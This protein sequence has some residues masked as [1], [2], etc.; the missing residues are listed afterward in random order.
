MQMRDCSA[1]ADSYKL[2]VVKN[3]DNFIGSNVITSIPVSDFYRFTMTVQTLM[4]NSDYRFR[5]VSTNSIGSD[6]TTPMSLSE[7]AISSMSFPL[8]CYYN[9]I[10]KH[11]QKYFHF[12]LFFPFT[13]ACVF[14]ANNYCL[15]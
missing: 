9:L 13:S 3:N 5:I 4:E 15:P 6:A 1:E 10:G 7:L 11:L 8:Q 2:E 14:L 12:K